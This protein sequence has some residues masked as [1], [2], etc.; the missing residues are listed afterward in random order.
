MASDI[1]PKYWVA[2]GSGDRSGTSG[3][4]GGSIPVTSASPAPTPSAMR[5]PSAIPQ[6]DRHDC[7]R[8]R[9]L[10]RPLTGTPISGRVTSILPVMRT[11]PLIVLVGLSK[12]KPGVGGAP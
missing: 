3:G 8:L 4:P 1:W 2:W 11:A 6:S 12:P 9:S 7:A 10:A 5:M